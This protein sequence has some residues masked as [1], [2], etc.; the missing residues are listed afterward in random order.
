MFGYFVMCSSVLVEG[1]VRLR[2]RDGSEGLLE[3][4]VSV[5][6]VWLLCILKGL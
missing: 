4:C 1:G 2:G 3:Y 5:L 6:K